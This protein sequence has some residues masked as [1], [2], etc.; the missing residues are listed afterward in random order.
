MIYTLGPVKDSYAPRLSQ[1]KDTMKIS[2]DEYGT[3]RF[4]FA[5][6]NSIRLSICDEFSRIASYKFV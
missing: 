4:S 6:E 1:V 2:L 5:Y 3:L